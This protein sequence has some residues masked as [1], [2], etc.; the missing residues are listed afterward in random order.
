M[1]PLLLLQQPLCKVFCASVFT[2]GAHT[3]AGVVI[4]VSFFLWRF[5]LKSVY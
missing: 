3:S 5:R 1:L 4:F 2:R